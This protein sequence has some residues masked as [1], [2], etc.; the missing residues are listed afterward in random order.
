[1]IAVTISSVT[2]LS[3]RGLRRI[4][5]REN[6]S[7]PHGTNDKMPATLPAGPGSAWSGGKRASTIRQSPSAGS[8]SRPRAIEKPRSVSVSRQASVLPISSCSSSAAMSR[9]RRTRVW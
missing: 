5:S 3:A 4:T 1:M 9:C 2:P 7:V 8:P 6:P